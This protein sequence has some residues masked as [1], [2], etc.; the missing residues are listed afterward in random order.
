MTT[1]WTTPVTGG[2]LESIC[3]VTVAADQAVRL[4]HGQ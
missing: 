4:H 1:P 2:D 3:T